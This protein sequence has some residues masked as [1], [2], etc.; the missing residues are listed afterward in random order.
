MVTKIIKIEDKLVEIV[1]IL[2]EVIV[3]V[4]TKLIFMIFQPI[5][6][7]RILMF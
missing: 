7:G 2:V 6:K 4:E 5:P 1:L 3:N